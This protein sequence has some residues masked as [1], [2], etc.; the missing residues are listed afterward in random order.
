[1]Y[2]YAYHTRTV[3]CVLTYEDTVLSEVRCTFVRKYFRIITSVLSKVQYSTVHVHYAALPGKC[4]FDT[5]SCRVSITACSFLY[6]QII[7]NS[8]KIAWYHLELFCFQR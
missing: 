6:E 2:T 4:I 1:M 8:Q 3:S 7:R 5:V